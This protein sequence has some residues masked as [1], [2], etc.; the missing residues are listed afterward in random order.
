MQQ[1]SEQ[2]ALAKLE[3]IAEVTMKNP[4]PMTVKDANSILAH[5]IVE[6][7]AD[8]SDLDFNKQVF[9]YISR[10]L[11]GIRSVY[12]NVRVVNLRNCQ[13]YVDHIEPLLHMLRNP[14]LE[15]IDLSRNCLSEEMLVSILQVLRVRHFQLF[16]LSHSSDCGY[17]SFENRVV[18]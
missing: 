3:Q 10:T 4:S 6:H 18:A 17:L 8:L 7:Y 14:K 11:F 16:S 13:L 2:I 12:E 9:I 5:R 1:K 15:A